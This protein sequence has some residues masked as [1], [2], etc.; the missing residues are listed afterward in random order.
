[1]RGQSLSLRHEVALEFKH[2][3]CHFITHCIKIINSCS[4]YVDWQLCFFIFWLKD[5]L[6]LTLNKANCTYSCSTLLCEIKCH[7]FGHHLGKG[8]KW[9]YFSKR[10]LTSLI[11]IDCI[12][13][14][15]TWRNPLE[16][17]GIAINNQA[18]FALFATRISSSPSLR[19][20]LT[21]Q[22]LCPAKHPLELHGHGW[23][24]RALQG[25]KPDW[26][27]DRP[28]LL[29]SAS[30]EPTP[31]LWCLVTILPFASK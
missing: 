2:S 26:S 20:Q 12:E 4:S 29:P 15:I 28:W 16:E 1:M 31:P 18:Y 23:G 19:Q 9:R 13:K 21:Q 10:Q 3:Y 22:E 6:L 14:K 17:V 24:Q 27:G 30:S 7:E 11:W 5:I 25:A 8:C